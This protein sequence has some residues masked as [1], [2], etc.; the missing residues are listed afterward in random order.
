MAI[1]GRHPICPKTI[2]ESRGIYARLYQFRTYVESERA[3]KYKEHFKKIFCNIFP[4]LEYS[5]IYFQD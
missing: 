4:R 5:V 1:E 3:P 2:T